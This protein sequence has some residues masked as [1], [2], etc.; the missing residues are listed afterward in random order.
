MLE[1]D[2]IDIS[3]EIH[4]N[5]TNASKECKI[6]YYWYFK[7]ISFKYEPYLCN[8][9]YSLMQK[10]ISFNYVAIV[11]VKGSACRIHF[12]YIGKDDAISIRNNS[13]LIVKKWVTQLIIKETEYHNM[14]E[15]KKQRLKEYQKNYREVKKSQYTVR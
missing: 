13:N 2:R 3:E 12:W 7:D 9:C 1:Y 10:A 5:K 11:F 8:G 14:S 6:L 4:I 15:E